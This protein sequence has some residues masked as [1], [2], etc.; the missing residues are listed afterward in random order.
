MY[1]DSFVVCRR[2]LYIINEYVSLFRRDYQLLGIQYEEIPLKI[3]LEVL[4]N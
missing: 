3:I 4:D 2:Y 1:L